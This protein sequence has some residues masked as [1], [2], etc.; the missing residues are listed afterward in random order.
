M[1]RAS[2]SLPVPDSPVISTEASDAATCSARRTVACIAGSR[3]TIAWLSPA[4]AS[5]I[6]AIRS[7]SG[8]SG[9]NS[10]APSRIACAAAS[11]SSPVPQATTGT[12]MR[13]AASAR[14][15][16]PTSCAR[17]HSTRSTRASAAQPRQRR[18]GVVRLVQLRAA[19]DRDARRLAELAGERAD[20]QDAHAG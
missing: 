18:V 4:A 5:R 19:R 2:T 9:R 3:T 15:R 8:G 17:S 10:R 6:A 1:W 20:D 11:A 12:A 7:G 13:S 14:T 16:A